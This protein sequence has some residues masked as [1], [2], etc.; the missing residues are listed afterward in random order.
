MEEKMF[1]VDICTTNS[2]LRKIKYFQT[3]T[4]R[5]ENVL[6]I[7]GRDATIVGFGQATITF[8]NDT[9]VAIE[10]ALL[11]PDSTRTLITFRD[12]RKS[13]LHVCIHEDNKDEFL[14]STKSF[15]YDHE[16]IERVPSTL[17]GLYYIYIKPIPYVA[18][19]VI[20]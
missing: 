1:L 10:Y 20:F 9:Q 15:R 8:L 2:I 7:V 14:L 6:A 11:Y 18:Y 5:S 3:L 13:G 17:S 16:V 12:I 4:R 19:K